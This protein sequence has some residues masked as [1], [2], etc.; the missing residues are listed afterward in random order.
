MHE[1]F[2]YEMNFFTCVHDLQ[3]F[4]FRS[5][6]AAAGQLRA[7][8]TDIIGCNDTFIS[9]DKHKLENGK[10]NVVEEEKLSEEA[11]NKIHSIQKQDAIGMKPMRE[12][13][14]AEA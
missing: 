13:E 2:C 11:S 1:I 8:I 12:V 6:E 7:W 9:N 5:D 10:T 14:I 3:L 4:V